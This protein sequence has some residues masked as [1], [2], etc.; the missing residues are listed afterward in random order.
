MDEQSG[1]LW[2]VDIGESSF[3]SPL[4]AGNTLYVGA[5]DES[6]RRRRWPPAQCGGGFAPEGPVSSSPRLAG[7]LVL[8]GSE[9]GAVYALQADDG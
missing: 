3:S 7:D 4:V 1:H 2:V 5:D 6:H 9:D 8:V